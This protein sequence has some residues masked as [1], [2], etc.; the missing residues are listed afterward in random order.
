MCVS[1]SIRGCCWSQSERFH[2]GNMSHTKTQR[3][4][5]QWKQREDRKLRIVR[6]KESARSQK[7][8]VQSRWSK[9]ALCWVHVAPSL[10]DVLLG[11]L[12]DSSGWSQALGRLL[13]LLWRVL[14]RVPE[15]P[16]GRLSCVSK[17][18]WGWQEWGSQYVFF[19]ASKQHCWLHQAQHDGTFKRKCSPKNEKFGYY[20]LAPMLMESQGKFQLHSKTM[21]R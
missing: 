11:L 21:L 7:S 15:Q 19:N 16:L 17:T 5:M 2:K 13:G 20:L 8:S 6:E 4:E 10:S 3:P 18:E 1:Y 14:H 9:K 12:W